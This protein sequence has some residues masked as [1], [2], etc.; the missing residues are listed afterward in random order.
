MGVDMM[1]CSRDVD[2]RMHKMDVDV[3]FVQ[4]AE[5]MNT[6]T[7]EDE[8]DEPDPWWSWDWNDEDWDE[9]DLE[10]KVPKHLVDA[11]KTAELEQLD[12]FGT[13]TLVPRSQML[14]DPRGK[15]I[16]TRW[17]MVNRGTDVKPKVKARLVAKEFRTKTG[18]GESLFSGTPGLAS[19]KMLLSDVATDNDGRILMIADVTGAFLYGRV[20]RR[21]YVTLPPESSA[22]PDQ[23]AL[24]EK[25]LY[26]LRDAPQIWKRHLVGTLATMDLAECRTMPGVLK[27]AHR[28]IWIVVHVDD[29]LCSGSPD[30]L[31]W[32]SKNL[33]SHYEL[34][35]QLIG[36]DHD[37]QG[38]YLKRTIRWDREGI[39]WAPNE[40]HCEIL[41]AEFGLEDCNP[42]RVPV[43]TETVNLETT[44][45]MSAEKSKQFRSAAARVNYLAQDR[46]DLAVASCLC[47]SRM[48]NPK[49]GDETILKKIARYL[50]GTPS[51]ATRFC[52]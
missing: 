41:M 6:N 45:P 35:T 28:R 42:V 18:R 20:N 30:D 50:K 33:K 47:A 12:K 34:K 15:T 13:W 27:H 7:A 40:K 19:I 29:L 8:W 23:V 1:F 16:D 22:G 39:T 5:Q 44:V 25:S 3:F 36:W 11:A 17:V 38:K 2:V 46:P 10:L 48:A 51:S 32:L 31:E 9:M 14:Q 37:N 4:P 52:W 43:T 24:L 49:Q 21:I 26:G